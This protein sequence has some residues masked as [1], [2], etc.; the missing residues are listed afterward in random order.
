MNLD[1][2]YFKNAIEKSYFI[3][4]KGA[5]KVE[6]I[7]NEVQDDALK[8]ICQPGNPLFLKSRQQGISSVEL[9]VMTILFCTVPNLNLVVI[10]HEI[11]ATQKLLDRVKFYLKSVE[12]RFGEKPFKLS[13]DNTN[14]IR[15]ADKG[16]TFYVGTAGAK[17]FGRSAT[18]N[19][20]LMS[21]IA[22][23]PNAEKVYNNLLEAIPLQGKI[24]IESTAN[25]F[26]TFHY[27]LW[28]NNYPN[29]KAYQ[30]QFYPWFKT[31]EY[32][33]TPP[34]DFIP[35][36]E[37]LTLANTYH[38]NRNQ[39]AWR[40]WKIDSKNGNLDSFMEEYPSNPVEAFVVSGNP[41]FARSLLEKLLRQVVEPTYQGNL[42]G[43]DPPTLEKNDKGY[44]RVFKLP[45]KGHQYVIGVD[46]AQGR[47]AGEDETGRKTDFSCAQV[48]DQTSFEQVAVWHG[49]TAPD[50]LAIEM[51][52]IG[53]YY[54]D[55]LIAVE[56][57]SIGIPTLIELKNRNYMN[58]YYREK[59]GMVSEKTTSEL[60]WYT[61]NSTKEIAIN[62]TNRL[63]REGKLQ[64]Y[65]EPTM[66]EMQAFVRGSNGHAGATAGS[67]DDRVMGLLIAA[68]MLGRN[69]LMSKKNPIEMNSEEQ[70][71]QW[72][73]GV[74]F[75][76]KSGMAI[77]PNQ[78]S[79][80]DSFLSDI[81]L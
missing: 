75:D 32:Q 23:W 18:I 55:A 78:T 26:G 21:E 48:L 29:P 64:L 40:R 61:D 67:W 43:W 59:F 41:V 54:N 27:N 72:M 15:N 24:F 63:L 45:Q 34:L 14:E 66:L 11:K 47:L 39:L 69:R 81:D 79:P 36:D 10:A 25:G 8:I 38:L 74:P 13:Y 49:K 52:R 76:K 12:E 5:E 58:L 70:D 73:S 1:Y 30:S 44:L 7:L 68:E 16:S 51:E 60:G 77:N 37:E 9:A 2:S 6:Y 35:T 42:I 62:D 65:D 57:N 19:V 22:Y 71:V 3:I 46:V 20:C 28:V 31:K 53:L 80:Q 33:I 50:L 4:D 17:N 56:R